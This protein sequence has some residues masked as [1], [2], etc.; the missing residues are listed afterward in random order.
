MYC[1]TTD[2]F[3]CSCFDVINRLVMK[4]IDPKTIFY[5]ITCD[6][7]M[8]PVIRYSRSNSKYN[9]VHR[10]VF[11]SSTKVYTHI[12][13]KCNNSVDL[14]A[15]LKL[16]EKKSINHY[17]VIKDSEWIVMKDLYKMIDARFICIETC[18]ISITIEDL[19]QFIMKWK[20]DKN[21]R[22]ENLKMRIEGVT[23]EMLTDGLGAVMKKDGNQ[24]I[25]HDIYRKR[26]IISVDETNFLMKI[27]Q[28]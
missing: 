22:L 7:F 26:A 21:C 1:T 19:K 10:T 2:R 4:H 23:I 15:V 12:L 28:F 27:Q 3:E 5:S 24:F 20:T 18:R 16:V 11:N 6:N 13:S 14:E 17:F 25:P 8:S 9:V